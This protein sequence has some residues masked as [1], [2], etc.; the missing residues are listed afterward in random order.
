MYPCKLYPEYDC[1]D[2]GKC[3]EDMDTEKP[4]RELERLE[5]MP[6]WELEDYYDRNLRKYDNE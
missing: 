3:D 2:C 5:D 1:D 4:E 6:E